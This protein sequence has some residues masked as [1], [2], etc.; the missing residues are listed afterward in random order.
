LAYKLAFPKVKRVLFDYFESENCV[1]GKEDESVS[2]NV[3]IVG[4]KSRCGQRKLLNKGQCNEPAE[5][6]E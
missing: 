2:C 3:V 1:C 4:L 5:E 6:F